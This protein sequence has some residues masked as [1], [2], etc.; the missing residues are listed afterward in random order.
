MTI[1]SLENDTS[2]YQGNVLS[3][4]LGVK[5]GLAIFTP[6][7]RLLWYGSRNYG[8]KNSLRND[9]PRLLQQYSPLRRL[10]MEGGGALYEVWDKEAQRRQIPVT[11]FHANYWRE[12]LFGSDYLMHTNKAKDKAVEMAERVIDRLGVHKFSAPVHHAA[13]AILAGLCFLYEEGRVVFPSE[14]QRLFR[15]PRSK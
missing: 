8:S 7:G 6:E 12:M 11:A 2:D 14:I 3:V 10:V 9:I 4:D 15:Y 1:P 5:T 13:E